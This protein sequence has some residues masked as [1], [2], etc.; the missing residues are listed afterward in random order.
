MLT[1]RQFLKGSLCGLAMLGLS[2]FDYAQPST[3]IEQRI[4]INLPAYRLRLHTFM[5]GELKSTDTYP[6]GIGRGYA[7]RPQTPIA[8][9]CVYEKRKRI[10]FRY[11]DDYP[12]LGIKKGDLIRWT[13]TFDEDGKPEGYKMP[14]EDMR[15]LGMKLSV[16]GVTKVDYVIH[17]TS[18]EFTLMTPCSSGCLRVGMDDM[19]RIYSSISP[20]IKDGRLAQTVPLSM[21]Y[22]VL[23]MDGGT[24]ILHAD[25]YE[26]KADLLEE[27]RKVLSSLGLPQSA[28]N[29]DGLDNYFSE[30][31]EQ[32]RIAK[33]RIFEKLLK[34]YPN[35]YVPQAY[36]DALH[37]QFGLQDFLI[38]S[39]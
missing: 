31:T 28:F 7:G 32:F 2:G 23:E 3:S 19:L 38:H 36:K 24:C 12:H 13:N 4:D 5:D 10:T 33:E 35:N 18:D 11:G 6:I 30:K 8:N 22:N 39:L 26:K 37:A 29:L 16:Q 34:H 21:E 20:E 27:F 14:Y 25:V 9:G 17:S 1:R 15:G